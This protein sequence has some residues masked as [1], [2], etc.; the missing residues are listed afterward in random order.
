MWHPFGCITTYWTAPHTTWSLHPSVCVH[1]WLF[2]S[3]WMWISPA[4]CLLRSE[5]ACLTPDCVVPVKVFHP[6]SVEGGRLNLIPKTGVASG[7]APYSSPL[8]IQDKWELYN[9]AN[10]HRQNTIPILF[11][12]HHLF[13]QW[14]RHWGELEE[15]N[16]FQINV[17]KILTACG[18][19]SD[20]VLRTDTDSVS[21][22]H[23]S[24][25]ALTNAWTMAHIVQLRILLPYKFFLSLVNSSGCLLW[26]YSLL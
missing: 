7:A 16:I 20:S 18:Y 26:Q 13:P 22:C 14:K 24:C 8:R 10:S 9:T 2:L 4:H 23:A 3:L 5:G 17:F 1:A 12:Q 25:T 11:E 21:M 6:C 15:A 19:Y